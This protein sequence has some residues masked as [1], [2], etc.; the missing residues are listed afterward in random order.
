MALGE[1]VDASGA[2]HTIDGRVCTHQVACMPI[3]LIWSDAGCSIAQRCGS[4]AGALGP[5]SGIDPWRNF[6]AQCLMI[7]GL[8]PRPVAPAAGSAL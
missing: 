2:A 1:E 5:A 3:Y 6:V 7:P 8:D 4:G